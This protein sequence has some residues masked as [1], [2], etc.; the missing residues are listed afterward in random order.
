MDQLEKIFGKYY[1]VD[2]TDAN[3]SGGIGMGLAIAKEL[4]GLHGGRIWAE[5]E[6]E[7]KG[8]RLTFTLPRG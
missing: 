1:Q 2:G 7:G 8:S 3:A 4:V 5:S 6:G